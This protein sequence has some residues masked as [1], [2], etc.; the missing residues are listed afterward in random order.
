[1]TDEEATEQVRNIIIESGDRRVERSHIL[2]EFKRRFPATRTSAW[3]DNGRGD[4][5]S[6]GTSAKKYV[7]KACRALEQ[8]GVLTRHDG[9]VTLC[10]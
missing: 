7:S 5:V 10:S 3:M 1:M 6:G 9:Y 2:S 8:E 4:L